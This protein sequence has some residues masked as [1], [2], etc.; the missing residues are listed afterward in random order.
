LI[1]YLK[2]MGYTHVEFLPLA[3]HPLDES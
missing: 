1:P 3:E 2:E